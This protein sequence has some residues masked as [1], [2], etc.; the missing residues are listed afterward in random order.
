MT[1]KISDMPSEDCEQTT[2]G[3]MYKHQ[4]KKTLVNAGPFAECSF[5]QNN[6]Q[7]L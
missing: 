5:T 4:S 2:D 6:Q 3:L 1:S 7:S